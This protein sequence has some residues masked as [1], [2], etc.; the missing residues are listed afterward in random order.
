MPDRRFVLATGA[1]A[2][3]ALCA[4][5]FDSAH[6]LARSPDVAR[7]GIPATP[8]GFS[9]PH[10]L[11]GPARLRPRIGSI[12]LHLAVGVKAVKPVNHLLAGIAATG[13]FKEGVA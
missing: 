3:A 9:V 5:F 4:P 2:S 7:A 13:V 12:G 10:R 6:Y 11:L 8:F 1:L